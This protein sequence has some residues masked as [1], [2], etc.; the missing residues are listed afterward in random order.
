MSMKHE[1]HPISQIDGANQLIKDY[2]QHHPADDSWYLCFDDDYHHIRQHMDQHHLPIHKITDIGCAWGVQNLFFQD[3]EYIGI[4][5]T[6][7][8]G[9]FEGND[10]SIP[11]FRENEKNVTYHVTTFPYNITSAMIG[12][13]FI[14]NMSVGYAKLEKDSEQDIQKAFSHFSY[15]YVRAPE[16]I[17]SLI[18]AVFPYSEMVRK[19]NYDWER[20]L[21]FVAKKK[22]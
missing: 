11:F 19:G 21:L 16:H 9:S 3:K 5:I 14:S 13:T 22:P 6:P 7:A 10:F 20:P 2:H 18:L 17:L 8:L 12:D 15:G 1:S 4:N